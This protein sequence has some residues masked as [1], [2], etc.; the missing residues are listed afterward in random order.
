MKV[1]LPECGTYY[2]AIIIRIVW[3][4]LK[5][6]HIDQWRKTE[7]SEISPHKFDLRQK[8]KGVKVIQWKMVFEINNVKTIGHPYAKKILKRTLT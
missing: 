4:W 2:K 6:R 8:R 7:S 3:Y 1:K 5:D